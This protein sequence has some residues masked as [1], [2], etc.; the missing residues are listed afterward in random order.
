MRE[1]PREKEELAQIRK[2]RLGRVRLE[3][4]AEIRRLMAAASSAYGEDAIALTRELQKCRARGFQISAALLAIDLDC[5]G[6]CIHCGGVIV[7]VRLE[8]HPWSVHCVACQEKL[9]QDHGGQIPLGVWQSTV[10]ELQS[11]VPMQ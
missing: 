1:V 5:Y 6:C 7:S 2:A 10:A 9:E 4:E 8:R 11:G 3:N